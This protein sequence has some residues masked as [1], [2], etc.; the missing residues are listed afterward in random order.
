MRHSRY[1]CVNHGRCR[2]AVDSTTEPAARPGACHECG[3]PLVPLAN[4]GLNVNVLAGIGLMA[5][6]SAVIL[7]FGLR[8]RFEAARHSGASP[9]GIAASFE[10]NSRML[11]AHYFTD[12]KAVEIMRL[13][14]LK[15]LAALMTFNKTYPGLLMSRG[16]GGINLAHLA[17]MQKDAEAFA[18]LLAAG[19]NKHAAADNGISPL[20]ASAMLPDARF[21]QAALA[22][23]A[24]LEQQDVLGRTALHLAVL[25]RQVSNVRLLLNAG[26]NPN[27]PDTHG[28][29]PWMAA[30]Q[31]RRPKR[32]IAALLRDH[33]AS[34]QNKDLSGLTARD[35]ALAF[36][37]PGL[38]SWFQ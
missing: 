22:G 6:L 16:R 25:H 34:S 9:A 8:W 17:L 27:Q 24:H 11:V 5:C 14:T 15:D 38:L 18:T 1:I 29:T 10:N 2:A 30:F 31:G 20:M 4:G 32:E 28:N 37:D 35:Y 3:E 21:L 12:P 19:V 13:A 26:A 7:F 23:G 36:D 33:G